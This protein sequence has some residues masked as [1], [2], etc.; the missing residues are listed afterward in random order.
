MNGNLIF[1]R[2]A[3]PGST[4]PATRL[5]PAAKR[6]ARAWRLPALALALMLGGYV[7]TADAATSMTIGGGALPPM[8]FIDFCKRHPDSCSKVRSRPEGVELT[9][10]RYA[11]LHDVQADVNRRVRPRRDVDQYGRLEHW[12]YPG[13]YGDCEDYALEKRRRLI[14]LGWP[15]SALLMALAEIKKNDHHLVLVV[16]TSKGDYVLDNRYRRVLPWDEL[17]YRW[18]K[19][20]SQEAEAAWMTIVGGKTALR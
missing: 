1:C 6:G 18:L 3:R 19:R 12:A 13:Q 16:A 2:A 14:A 9:R 4:S 5:A 7:P 10:Q 8:G 15:R 17:P 11:Q 20:Q